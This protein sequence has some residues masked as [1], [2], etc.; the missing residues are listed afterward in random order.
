MKFWFANKSYA[1]LG[2]EFDRVGVGAPGPKALSQLDLHNP[3]LDWVSLA[4]GMGVAASKAETLKEF[5]E[6]FERCMQER[7]PHLIEV[8][9]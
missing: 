3:E 2:I 4:S 9:L 6:Q 7:G 5:S 1:I 8:I